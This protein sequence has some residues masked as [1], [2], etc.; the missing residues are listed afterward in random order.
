M[1]EKS[2]ILIIIFLILLLF[3]LVISIGAGRKKDKSQSPEIK[4]YLFGVRALIIIIGAVSTILW[5]FL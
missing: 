4:R 5:F 2:T 3:Y 1:F